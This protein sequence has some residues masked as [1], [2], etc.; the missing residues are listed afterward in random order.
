[1]QLRE[2]MP[3]REEVLARLASVGGTRDEIDFLHPAVA[4]SLGGTER[5]AAGVV[6]SIVVA[7]RRISVERGIDHAYLGNRASEYARAVLGEGSS[8]LEGVEFM[9]SICDEGRVEAP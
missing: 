9:T 1:M 2:K 7:M 3:E 8:L 6:F 4:D 5:T